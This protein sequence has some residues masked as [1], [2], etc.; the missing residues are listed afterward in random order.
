MV[1]VTITGGEQQ[2]IEE[3]AESTVKVKIKDSID[4]KMSVSCS[5]I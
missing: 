5:Q 1:N 4:V 2:P 3:E